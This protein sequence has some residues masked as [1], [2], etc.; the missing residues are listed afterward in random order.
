MTKSFSFQ[1]EFDLLST[2]KET[3]SPP[4]FRGEAVNIHLCTGYNSSQQLLF[5]KAAVVW[6]RQH[7]PFLELLGSSEGQRNLHGWLC[8]G[9]VWVQC[10]RLG[11]SNRLTGNTPGGR[12]VGRTFLSGFQLFVW[13][14]ILSVFCICYLYTLLSPLFC[15]HGE[16]AS[17]DHMVVLTRLKNLLLT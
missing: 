16:A 9:R 13:T 3:K 1:S 17:T 5:W 12:V 11:T 10:P 8:R 7:C 6:V 14:E 15:C 2:L 4:Y